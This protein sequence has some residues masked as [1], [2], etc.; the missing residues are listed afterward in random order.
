MQF[1]L[2]SAREE[3]FFYWEGEI[4][5]HLW[6]I[7][8]CCS[9]E[10]EEICRKSLLTGK[11][12]QLDAGKGPGK[13]SLICC[14]FN[15]T[16]GRGHEAGVNPRR[17]DEL[18]LLAK[19]ESNDLLPR[20]FPFSNDKDGGFKE[21]SVEMTYKNSRDLSFSMLGVILLTVS[22]RVIFIIVRSVAKPGVTPTC[23][24]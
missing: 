8:R 16:R 18:L 15:I 3:D 13:R 23:L 19:S 21:K 5:T 14:K 10:M 7:F 22:D 2:C 4:G 12:A 1:G 17:R 24:L 6:G 9:F 20:T 11:H